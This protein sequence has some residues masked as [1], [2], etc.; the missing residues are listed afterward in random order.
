MFVLHLTF[1]KRGRPN[2][3]FD[4]KFKLLVTLIKVGMRGAYN[5]IVTIA[6][7][8]RTSELDWTLVRMPF[9]NN[10]PK[11]GKVR[12]GYFGHGIIRTRLS[13][14]DLA[15]FMLEQLHDPTYIQKAPTLSK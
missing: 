14:A 4:F 1:E 7:A 9:L 6:D 2:D 3:R 5:E 12:I 8:I 15:E 11:T 13:R 10:K